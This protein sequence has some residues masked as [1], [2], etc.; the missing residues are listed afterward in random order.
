MT[1]FIFVT[2]GVVS[3]IGKGIVA[4]SLGR[5]LKSRDYS[6]SI[7]KLDPYINIDPGTMS[8]FQHGEVFVT[9]DG[10]ETD[11]DLGHYERFTDTSMSRLNSV[12][13]GSIYQAVINKERRGDYNGGT[14]Q[15][16]PHITNEIK[17]RII[18]VAQNTNPSV[19]ITEIGG[20]V[21][22]IES[23]PFLE[24]IRQLR[25]EVGRQNVL[26]MHVT[27]VPWI[28]SAGEMKTKPTQHSVKELRSI[29]I[30]PDILVCRCDR[31]LPVGLKRK[32]SEFCD[33]PEECVITAQD[34]GSIYE[35][36]LIL[37]GEGL[38]EQALDLLQMEQRQPNLTQWQT[39]V[40]RL[41]S[42][43]YTVEIAIVGKYVR[44]SDAYLSVVE[45]LRHAAIATYGDLR[46]RW[47]N[48]EELET[49]SADSYLTGVDGIL[50]PGGFGIRGVDGKI[51]AIKY[52]RDHQIPFLGLCLGMQCSVIEWARNLQGLM[53]A[54]SSEFDPET[55]HPIIN[56]LPEQENVVDLGGTMRLGLYP[57]HLAPNS[58]AA[59]LYQQE[60]VKE[61]HRHRYEFNNAYR[62]MLLNSGYV[63]S[64][65][66]PDGRLVEIVEFP[67]HPFFLA[68]Q[69]HPEFHS[70]PSTPHPLFKGFMQAAI[71]RSHPESNLLTR[72]EVY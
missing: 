46:L 33:V 40:E 9:E 24:A 1:K 19:L 25:K 68:C 60:V 42:P 20:T 52:A 55:K 61:R 21:G 16:I 65:T 5:L 4:A 54:N 67:E 36:P 56:L 62:N 7:L 27:L 47:V 12:T 51:A 23:L 72:V 69:F 49:E 29:G 22:D 17:E 57:C 44:L 34:A 6:V 45:A 43:K 3:S 18:R 14:V 8:P 70:R 38:A 37:E 15:V 35:V 48:S 31:S 11:L 32:L 50:V 30:Q 2:G 59:N 58:L 10:A 63:I 71:N 39:M 64:G 66:S 26:Y 53:G 13:T 28:A 41:Y